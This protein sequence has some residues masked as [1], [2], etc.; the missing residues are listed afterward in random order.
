MPFQ[1]AH[2]RDNEAANDRPQFGLRAI[3]WTFLVIGMSLAYLRRFESPQVF[4][5]AAFVLTMATIVG[6]A[7]GWCAGR[8]SDAT[9]WSVVITSAAFLSVA[10]ERANGSMFPIAWSA[11]G[12]TAGSCCGLITPSRLLRRMV[13]GCF[14]AGATMLA[15]SAARTSGTVEIFFDLACAPAI[16]ALVG[17]LIELIL[18][19]ERKRCAPRYLTASWLLC[20]VIIGNLLVPL[21]HR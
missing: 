2:A 6:A 16:G 8:S 21:M 15:F 13:T 17:L 5:E 19:L 12:T 7:I 3:L 10:G 14:V 9:Y 20:A 4:L 18:W 11:V 1:K